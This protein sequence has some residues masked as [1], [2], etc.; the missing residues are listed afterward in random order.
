MNKAELIAMV[1]EKCD[2]T[3]AQVETVFKATFDAIAEVLSK[4][5]K[6]MIPWFGG[7]SSKKRPARKGRNPS[8]GQEMLIPETV[9][10][11]FKSAA[12]LKEF[13]NS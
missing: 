13:I 8:T 1:T 11:S 4:Q 3:K 6:I 10:A 12:Q 7:F 5:D 9:V 2:L